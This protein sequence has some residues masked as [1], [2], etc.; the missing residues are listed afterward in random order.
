MPQVF[1]EFFDPVGF[2]NFV[3]DGMRPVPKLLGNFT[4]KMYKGKMDKLP[5]AYRALADKMN[6][7][8]PEQK[9]NT[10]F[11]QKYKSGERVY[12][13][14]D[15]MNNLNHT[16]IAIFGQF[17][18]AE[19]TIYLDGLTKKIQLNSGDVLSLECTID[20]IQGPMHEVS[21]VTQGTRYAFI[22][23]TIH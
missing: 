1:R 14:R 16:L 13:H 22:L 17:S 19:T 2:E 11:I 21:P 7:I 5:L 8:H 9:F 6:E 12:K 20:G 15:P 18:G 4:F 3:P 10:A 23:N